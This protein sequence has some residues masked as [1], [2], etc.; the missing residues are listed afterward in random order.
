MASSCRNCCGT[1]N[2]FAPSIPGQS[3]VPPT[4]NCLVT[5]GI[6]RYFATAFLQ[7]ALLTRHNAGAAAVAAA[8]HELGQWR[9]LSL[10][11]A[12]LHTNCLI[13]ADPPLQQCSFHLVGPTHLPAAACRL[14]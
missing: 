14:R 11:L 13:R 7:C 4:C 2:L 8:P 12:F 3:A 5:A 1:R 9:L 6:A 10:P